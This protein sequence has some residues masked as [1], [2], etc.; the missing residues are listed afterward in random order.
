[1][2][3]AAWGALAALLVLAALSLIVPPL[4]GVDPLAIDDVLGARLVAPMARDAA[5]VLHPLGTD[6][7][8]RDVLLR[9]LLA[10]RISLAG[11]GGS[12]LATAVGVLVGAVSGWCAAPSTGSRWRGRRAPRHPAPHPAPLRHALAPASRP[13]AVLALTGWMSVARLVRAEVGRRPH[14]LGGAGAR[15]RRVA[16]AVA[17]RPPQ[18]LGRDR[19]AH[20]GV[21]TPCCWER[22]GL[23][24]RV[25]PP[26]PSWGT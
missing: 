17:A 20:A 4:S 7:F 21:A 13:F 26:T 18:A 2:T 12:L 25:Q 1:V 5:G 3:R 8:G 22:V 24:T 19:R 15:R 16:R 11:I 9:M 10:T 23:S 14:A 6:R